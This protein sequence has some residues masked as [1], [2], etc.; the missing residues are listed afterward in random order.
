MEREDEGLRNI[1]YTYFAINRYG[2]RLVPDSTI[3]GVGISFLDNSG[4][5]ETAIPNAIHDLKRAVA[6]SQREP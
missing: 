4:L 6:E 2:S 1:E 3:P 5:G